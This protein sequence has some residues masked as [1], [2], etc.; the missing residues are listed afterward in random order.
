MTSRGFSENFRGSTVL[1]GSADDRRR[2]HGGAFQRIGGNPQES[3]PIRPDPLGAGRDASP[4]GVYKGVG[5]K[6]NGIEREFLDSKTPN[7]IPPPWRTV[8]VSYSAESDA[9][10]GLPLYPAV[11][12]CISR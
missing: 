1:M 6:H 8:F 2:E 3:P 5:R 7:M 12:R 11:S 10:P 9:I 4:L